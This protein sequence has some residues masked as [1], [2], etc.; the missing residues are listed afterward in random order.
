MAAAASNMESSTKRG[1][2]DARRGRQHG[3]MSHLK[4]ILAVL[5]GFWTKISNDSI[6]NLSATLAYNF[7]MSAFPI[8]LVILAIGGIILQHA[9][10]AQYASFQN[11]LAGAFPGGTGQDVMVNVTHNLN[12]SAGLLLII[13]IVVAVFTGSGL[14][15]T[16]EWTFGIVF[17]LRGR[18]P[19]RQRLMSIGMLL[20]YAVLIPIIIL[21]SLLPSII[22]RALPLGH[23]SP[24]ASFFV[25]AAGDVFSVLVAALLFG[26]IYVVVPNRK[27]E[28]SEVW[29]GTLVAALLLVLYETLFPFYVS[30]FLHPQNFGSTAGFA[31]VILIFFYYLAFIL[32]LGA[33][34]NS[35]AAGQHE[36][37]GDIPSIL[38]ELQAHNTT[39]GAAGPTAGLPQED[40]AHHK[41]A[42]AMRTPDAAISHERDDHKDSAQPPKFAESGVN[43]PGYNVEQQGTQEAVHAQTRSRHDSEALQK[44][45]LAEKVP[46]AEAQARELRDGD[47]GAAGARGSDNG[48]IGGSGLRDDTEPAQPAGYRAI[49]A[50]PGSL[51]GAGAGTLALRQPLAVRPLSRREKSALWG[52]LAAGTVA[53]VPILRVLL[54]LLRDG[55]SSARRRDK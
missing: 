45:R 19:I 16:L 53:V 7:L 52:V 39:R 50:T 43:A 6:F 4:P 17:R 30:T 23:N 12:H 34:I 36:T 37:A 9:S 25:Q 41:G 13:G 48:S 40:M 24:V 51:V 54:D 26:A 55:D 44:N 20:L 27:V 47:T 46:A 49:A 10:P 22:V 8:L 14:F 42:V 5:G 38:H 35:W 11:T 1:N 31:V 2:R 21:A 32:V 28:W 33:E 3:M 29:K 15:L 18:N